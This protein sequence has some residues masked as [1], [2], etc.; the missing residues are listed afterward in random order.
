MR[1]PSRLEACDLPIP[2]D[3]SSAVFFL[4]AAL[5]LPGSDLRIEGVGLNPTR[6]AV[7]DVLREM[8]A[9][10]RIRAVSRSDP[11]RSAEQAHSPAARSPVQRPPP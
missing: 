2:S 8:G 4:A 5:L 7:L 6:T 1:G 11:S 10:V 9:A 3:L